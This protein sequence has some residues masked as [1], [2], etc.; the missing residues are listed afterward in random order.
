MRREMTPDEIES[1]WAIGFSGRDDTPASKTKAAGTDR[2]ILNKAIAIVEAAGLVVSKPR[3]KRGKKNGG[4]GPVFEARFNDNQVTRMTVHQS[5]E[6]L[7]LGRGARLAQAAYESRTRKDAPPIV[8]AH[9]EREG[10]VLESYGREQ[11]DAL[12]EEGAP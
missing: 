11:L 10:E 4:P 3:S 5:R 2:E 7:D 9:Y 6:R 1:V 8:E 12:S